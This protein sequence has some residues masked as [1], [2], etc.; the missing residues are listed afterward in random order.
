MIC[1]IKENTI[2]FEVKQKKIIQFS[3]KLDIPVIVSENAIT[4]TKK[5]A[6]IVHRSI[7]ERLIAT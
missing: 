4:R 1:R 7:F 3:N 2:L 6:E 5:V